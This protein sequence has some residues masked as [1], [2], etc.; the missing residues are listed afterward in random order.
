MAA[1]A[2]R[3]LLAAFGGAAAWPLA[4]R[5]QQHT[6]RRRRV[7]ALIGWS[8]TSSYRGNLAAFIERLAQLGWIDGRNLQ[9]EQRWTD[10]NAERTPSLAG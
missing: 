1:I 3:K 8:D 6:E 9:L 7:A 4:A 5:A 2:R 10:A